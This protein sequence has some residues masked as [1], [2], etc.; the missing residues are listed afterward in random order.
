MEEPEVGRFDF[1]DGGCYIGQWQ[2]GRAHGHGLATG[3]NGVGEF[4][5]QWI[6][7]YEHSGV[8]VWPNGHI[9]AGNWS[10]GRRH[11]FGA[12]IK[13]KWIY[14]GRFTMGTCG[15]FGIK[16]AVNS[17]ATYEGSWQLNKFEGFGVEMCSDGSKF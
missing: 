15:P 9:Y 5:G 2:D 13:G 16:T 6:A 7:G 11:G 14:Q 10:R 3:P 1:E 17:Q 12:Q 8:Y 4:S